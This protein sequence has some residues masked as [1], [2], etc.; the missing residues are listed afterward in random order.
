MGNLYLWN[1][2][3]CFVRKQCLYPCTKT[4]TK[5]L[6]AEFRRCFSEDQRNAVSFTAK[7]NDKS[8]VHPA[9]NV[10]LW[11][12][13]SLQCC[14]PRPVERPFLRVYAAIITGCCRPHKTLNL[15]VCLR[16]PSL[17]PQGQYLTT[18]RAGS[19]GARRTVKRASKMSAVTAKYVG[20]R[21]RG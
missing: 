3:T 13:F 11:H 14:I 15:P 19:V 4:I 6:R 17:G 8:T 20:R 9:T 12:P 7:R 2:R 10:C 5:I 16:A 21:C 1:V 18:F